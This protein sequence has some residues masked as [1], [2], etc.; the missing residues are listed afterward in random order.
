MR[1]LLLAALG[2]AALGAGGC[3]GDDGSG[4]SSAADDGATLTKAQ[5]ITAADRICRD[6][7]A[8]TQK[9][10]DQ[11]DALPEGSGPAKLRPIL[12][13]GLAE[14]RRGVDRLK[15]LTVPS[16]DR[17]TVDSYF[18]SIDRSIVAYEALQNAVGDEDEDEARKIA[19]AADPLFDEQRRL[20]KAYGF[21]QCRSV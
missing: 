19:A 17:A 21:K 10:A 5:Y 12:E 9:Y 18:A 8:K 20:A 3:G 1:R 11:V 7:D 15:A 16:A 4:T 6:V 2:S 14:T 13:A